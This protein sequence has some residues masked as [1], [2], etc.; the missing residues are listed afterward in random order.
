MELEIECSLKVV[1]DWMAVV[2]SRL[3]DGAGC[4]L[5][6]DSTVVEDSPW[7]NLVAYMTIHPW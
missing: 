7:N 1:E 4:G 6:E 3:A 5:V 2:D